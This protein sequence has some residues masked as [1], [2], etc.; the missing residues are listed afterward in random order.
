MFVIEK[1]ESSI[2][3]RTPSKIESTLQGFDQTF[4]ICP[5]DLVNEVPQRSK[6]SVESSYG[7]LRMAL[8]ISQ[9]TAANRTVQRFACRHGVC[10]A[11]VSF[12]IRDRVVRLTDALFIH[13]HLISE[14]PSTGVELLSQED[15]AEIAYLISIGCPAGQIRLRLGLSVPSQTLYNARRG[16]LY[17]YRSKKSAQLE[18]NIILYKDF[19]TC[20]ARHSDCLAGCYFLHTAFAHSTLWS[21]TV[22][23][24]DTFS[25]N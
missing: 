3:E 15:R 11:H 23:M 21:E 7:L 24:D 1:K 25:T 16:H 14:I 6:V 8:F 18:A 17:P 2:Q 4:T 9:T 5:R 22:I 20:L 19:S 10:P 13:N 12:T